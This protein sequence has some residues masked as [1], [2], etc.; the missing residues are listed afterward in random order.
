M[1][2][3]QKINGM[4]QPA[5]HFEFYRIGKMSTKLSLYLKKIINFRCLKKR[6]HCVTFQKKCWAKSSKKAMRKTIKTFFYQRLKI[7]IERINWKDFSI[8]QKVK[9]IYILHH[10]GCRKKCCMF[11]KLDMMRKRCHQNPF[12]N[13]KSA[14]S[15]G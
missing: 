11:W 2:D 14:Y 5:I 12:T 7:E 15:T 10:N 4:C 8:Q 13:K 6:C 9:N 3:Y 1:T